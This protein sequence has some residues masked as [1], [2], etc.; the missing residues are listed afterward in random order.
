M[1]E[2]LA[3]AGANDRRTDEEGKHENVTEFHPKENGE[4]WL[5]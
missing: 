3:H 5:D 2:S 4:G 1:A